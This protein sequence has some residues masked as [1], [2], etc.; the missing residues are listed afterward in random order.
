MVLQHKFFATLGADH[1]EQP[2]EG[3]TWPCS[4]GPGIHEDKPFDPRGMADGETEPNWS[5]PVMQDEC[6]IADVEME[7]QR[8]KIGDMMVQAIGVRCGRHTGFPHTHMVRDNA[9]S[10]PRQRRDELTIQ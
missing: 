3:S 1:L 6:H 8:C 5:T 10:M 9:T 4:P 2:R 7:H